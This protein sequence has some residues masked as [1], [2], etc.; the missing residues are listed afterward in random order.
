MVCDTCKKTNVLRRQNFCLV[1]DPKKL[2]RT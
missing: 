1:Q 2:N